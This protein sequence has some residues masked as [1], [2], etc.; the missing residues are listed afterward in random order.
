[1]KTYKEYLNESM[2]D[3]E[4]SLGLMKDFFTGDITIEDMMKKKKDMMS[5][6]EAGLIMKIPSMMKMAM[7]KFKISEDELTSKLKEVIKAL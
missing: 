7:K 4:D 6:G 1:M 2:S 5:K 3:I